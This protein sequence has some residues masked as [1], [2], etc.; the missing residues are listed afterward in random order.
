MQKG[1]KWKSFVSNSFFRKI[2]YL[3]A[4]KDWERESLSRRVCPKNFLYFKLTSIRLKI[5][6]L[7]SEIVTNPIH[8]IN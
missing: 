5:L 2:H 8:Q 1:L 7:T 3:L 6:E 4:N